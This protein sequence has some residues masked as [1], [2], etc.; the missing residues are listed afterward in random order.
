VS[1][2]RLDLPLYFLELLLS[3]QLG[4]AKPVQL[5]SLLLLPSE[6]RSPVKSPLFFAFLN[7]GLTLDLILQ[8][9]N[10]VGGRFYP[11]IQIFYSVEFNVFCRK[12]L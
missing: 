10:D 12:R 3:L 7:D 11:E 5:L 8:V 9:G 4:Q 2:D 1:E 6:K